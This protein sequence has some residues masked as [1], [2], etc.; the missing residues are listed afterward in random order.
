MVEKASLKTVNVFVNGKTKEIKMEQ[1]I[2]FEDNSSI[3]KVDED[4]NLKRYNKTSNVWETAS[5]IVMENYQWKAFQNVANNDDDATTYTKADVEK[6]ME[7]YGNGEFKTDM[8]E[9]LP[10]GYRI[11]KPAKYT[12]ENLVQAYVTNG[13]E[14]QS[15]TLKFKIENANEADKSEA[16]IGADPELVK[17]YAEKFKNMTSDE[18][19]EALKEQIYGLSNGKKTLS[20]YDAIPLDRLKEVADIY[21]HK[22]ITTTTEWEKYSNQYEEGMR[23]YKLTTSELLLESMLMEY[24]ISKNELLP[25]IQR[26]VEYCEENQIYRSPL[27]LKV[28]KKEIAEK[29]LDHALYNMGVAEMFER[30]VYKRSDE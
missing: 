12:N 26:Y 4:L 14:S 28:A 15:A 11:E 9:D 5:S 21:M 19:A 24:G 30:A 18:I 17:E 25:R 29:D 7:L 1:G 13:E 6:A 10:S 8:S 16:L 20:M 27:H 3:Y 22:T 2:S 23:K